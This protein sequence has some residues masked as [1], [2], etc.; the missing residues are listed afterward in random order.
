[1]GSGASSS[2]PRTSSSMTLSSALEVGS[3]LVT[4][5]SYIRLSR[6]LGN[7]GGFGE[8]EKG[9]IASKLLELSSE[10]GHLDCMELLISHLLIKDSPSSH[11]ASSKTLK[12]KLPKYLKVQ[13]YPLHVASSNFQIDAL[14]ILL[15]SGLS[16]PS[17]LDSFSQTALHRCCSSFP[18]DEV[19][20]EKQEICVSILVEGMRR[21]GG[22]SVN[23]KDLNGNTPLHLSCK[24]GN[25]SLTSFLLGLGSTLT[26]RNL[27][28]KSPVDIAS[29]NNHIELATSLKSGRIGFL[30]QIEGKRRR[31]EKERVDVEKAMAIWECFFVNAMKRNAGGGGQDD[32][33]VREKSEGGGTL[34]WTPRRDD[35][36]HNYNNPLLGRKY[37]LNIARKRQEERGEKNYLFALKEEREKA[38]LRREGNEARN[39]DRRGGRRKDYVKLYESSARFDD[40]EEDS[41]AGGKH[42]G[43]EDE[44]EMRFETRQDMASRFS[45]GSPNNS[46]SKV[47]KEE[48]KTE[49]KPETNEI[50]EEENYSG[51]ILWTRIH[52]AEYDRVYYFNSET[53]QSKWSRPS[54]G[55]V[56][57]YIVMFDNE[58]NRDFYFYDETGESLWTIRGEE[59]EEKVEA[60]SQGERVGKVLESNNSSEVEMEEKYQ[61]KEYE[62][63]SSEAEDLAFEGGIQK[64]AHL[65]YK[66]PTLTTDTWLGWM[67]TYE[68][69]KAKYFNTHTL[70]T[71]FNPPSTPLLLCFD[72]ASGLYYI[73]FETG[74]SRWSLGEWKGVAEGDVFYYWNSKTG[75][76]KWEITVDD[77]G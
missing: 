9:V 45:K 2:G 57:D 77:V 53:E 60:G 52:D 35:Y 22:E 54:S 8:V 73:T 30:G 76:T 49:A 36:N 65:T 25:N 3:D 42:F 58:E 48:E 6:F 11:R 51:D 61:E 74:D 12:N 10:T 69:E 43:K 41:D 28:F 29:L 4:N 56:S 64:A 21:E 18:K 71:T 68:N 75:E 5:G 32:F 63:E 72:E 27:K 47:E 44:K 31:G 20:I 66:Q 40:V 62:Y 38:R 7:G 23:S 67:L 33:N 14:E 16:S 46:P 59:N 17:S 13:G 15:I 1:M 55:R 34:S 26:L 39:V 70:E 50:N 19:E 24:T 37:R